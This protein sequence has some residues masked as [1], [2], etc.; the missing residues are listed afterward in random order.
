[1]RARLGRVNCAAGVCS[2]L[3]G[4]PVLGRIQLNGEGAGGGLFDIPAG[5]TG[6]LHLQAVVRRTNE[7]STIE[8]DRVGDPIACRHPV[9][10]QCALFPRRPTERTDL[11][12]AVD[13]V[14]LQGAISPYTVQWQQR[15]GPLWS[16]LPGATGSSLDS[17][18]DRFSP[19]S[20]YNCGVGSE[21]RVIC[22]D[23][24]SGASMPSPSIVIQ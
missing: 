23:T 10:P 3:I 8:Q 9:A 13:F 4:G 7:V 12:A 18:V 2:P 6:D 1:M 17:C 14:S 24:R 15:F 21:L 5:M 11:L 20:R 19:A 16:D 22:T